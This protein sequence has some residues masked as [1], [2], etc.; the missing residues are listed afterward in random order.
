[1]KI[2]DI[3]ALNGPNYW[4]INRHKLIVMRLDLEE[5][6]ELPSDKIDG[7]YERLQ[8]LMPSLYDHRC[9]EGRPGGFFYRVERG[10]WMGHIIEHIALELQALAGIECG[11][12]RTRGTGEYGIYNVVVAYQEERAGLLAVTRAVDIAQSLVDGKKYDIQAD[13]SLLARLYEED[14]LG[15]STS[16]I[17]NACLQKGIPYIRLDNESTIQLG[18]GAR[19]KRI[20]AT[21]TSQTS[22]IAVELAGD[23]N[24]TK[25]RLKQVGIPVPIGE[26]VQ[27]E[28]AIQEVRQTLNFP[29][30]VKPLDGNHG[31][32]VT[33]NI[34]SDDALM[35]AFRM[36]KQHR[37][38]VLVE[39]FID[40]NDY[41]LLVIDYKL[42]AAARRIPAEVTGDG[43]STIRQLVDQINFD[44]RRGEGHVNLLTKI[45]LDEAT[46]ML[47]AEQ[48]LTLESVLPAG[49]KLFLKKTANLSTGGTAIDVTD[50]VHPEIRVMAERTARAIG[51]D[52]CGIDLIAQDITRPLKASGASVI[53]VNAAP[54]FR[55]HIHP[56]EGKPREVGKA[57]AEMLF[58][59]NQSDKF[60][61]APGRIPIV[62]ITG[63]N[64]K[65]T[66]TRLIRHIIRQL[67][68]VVGCTT[69]DGVYID[70]TL[71][72]S[73]DCTGPQ[74]S[75]KVLQDSSV[76]V[77]VLEC[78][79]GGM[80]RSGLA[81]DQCDVGIVT[82]VASDHLGL[83]DIHSLEDMA[84]VK[85]I[86][87]ESVKPDGY[88]VLNADNTYTYAMR[89]HVR[90]NV[91]LFSMNP[92]GE[93]I[94]AHYRAGGLAAVY[95]DEF[96]TIRRGDERIQIEHVTN[97]PL[98]F[99]GKAP[100]MI[101]N[102]LAAALG[103]YCQHI[104][105]ALIAEGLRSFIPSFENTPGRM[106]FFYF[107]NFCVL[108]DYAH[109]P[110]GL[111]ALGEYIKQA[112]AGRT[113]GILTGVGDRRDEDIIE[114]GRV[115]VNIFDDIIIRFDEDSRG[116]DTAQI[117]D[118]IMQGI[119]EVNP[120]KSVQI[121][122]DELAA[123]TYAI[124]NAPNDALIVHLSDRVSQSVKLVEACQ[125]R[126]LQ[127]AHKPDGL[128]SA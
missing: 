31:R 49:C 125:E 83:R 32:G 113:I 99:G 6:E 114:V 110:H 29:L 105:V 45:E 2:Q 73:G 44:P 48:G 123:L 77:A 107:Q 122:P 14:R 116:R 28:Q 80:L 70:D 68:C 76:D 37:P 11:F 18:Y 102:I 34:Q 124:Q 72:E 9:S 16:A 52:I 78:A 90:S 33:T 26:V 36:A 58:P 62:A 127:L 25:R 12:G 3:R 61:S 21:I 119:R 115:S 109:N 74:S 87:A 92:T 10:T 121:I 15:P 38:N 1:M 96:I 117:A 53:E 112:G 46:C 95:E 22:S 103:A 7:F 118:L 41:R 35:A 91:A 8:R 19:H 57:V 97:I 104:S 4:S 93:R 54:G 27:T 120:Q 126:E 71:I 128:V 65:T 82:N 69:T 111:V 86:V 101:E 108:V 5:L 51:L 42:C 81:F 20:Q 75:R 79:R 17:V 23:K 56:S 63:T 40:G 67:G 39:Q 64:G 98:S 47:L 60:G 50:C 24:E 30:T 84:R 59:A 94:V 13:L 66:T 88:A 55:M 100:F 89:Q 85:A 43:S 106:N